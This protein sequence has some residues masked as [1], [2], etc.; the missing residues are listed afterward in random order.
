[1]LTSKSVFAYRKQ[2]P[3]DNCFFSEP[4][5]GILIENKEEAFISPFD[6][7]DEVFLI[8]LYEVKKSV[9]ICFMR[10]GI[11]LNMPLIA[12]T[13]LFKLNTSNQHFEKS[14]CFFIAFK[15]VE[16]DQ[17]KILKRW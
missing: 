3:D 7:T 8:G 5:S 16:I 15:P 9:V 6:E 1:M 12:Y 2:F 17:I 10:N 14:E 13:N 11:L 4:G